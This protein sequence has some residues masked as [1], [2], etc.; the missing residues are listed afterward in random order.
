MG[1]SPMDY[2]RLAS[3]LSVVNFIILTIGITRLKEHVASGP[4]DDAPL[5]TLRAE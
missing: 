3:S 5:V 2:W 4:E 1:V